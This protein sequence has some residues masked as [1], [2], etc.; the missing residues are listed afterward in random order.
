[1]EALLDFKEDQLTSSS[2]AGEGLEIQILKSEALLIFIANW[3]NYCN[4]S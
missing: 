3:L 2:R 1:M 4:H